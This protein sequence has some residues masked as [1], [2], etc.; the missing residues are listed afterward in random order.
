MEMEQ[1]ARE[2]RSDDLQEDSSHL[3]LESLPRVL[4]PQGACPLSYGL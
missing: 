1:A 2:V 3:A 4:F